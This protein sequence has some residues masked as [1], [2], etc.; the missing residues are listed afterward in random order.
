MMFLSTFLRVLPFLRTLLLALLCLASPGARAVVGGIVD[1]NS[2]NSPFAGVG[3][4][5]RDGREVYSAVLIAPQ[6]A[7]TAAHVV[8]RTAL[9]GTY[10]FNL[11]IGGDLTFSVPVAEIVVHPDYHGF[12][13][14]PDGLVHSDLAV[15]RLASAVPAG[16][17]IYE[18]Y[19]GLVAGQEIVFVGYG[20][21]LDASGASVAPAASVKRRGS[22]EVER[23]LPAQGSG[24][25]AG[26]GD[27]FVFRSWPGQ[28]A[29]GWRAGLAGGDSGG[30]AFVQAPDGRLE[31]AGI[32]TFV[33]GAGPAEAGSFIAGGGGIVVA[34]H[35]PWIKSVMSELPEPAT[36]Q[37]AAIGIALAIA[38]GAAALR[39]AQ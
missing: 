35:V 27:V 37:L 32:N 1:Q 17:P 6:Y 38:A 22:S 9:P 10:T 28:S 26:Q 14:G 2:A 5:I 33:F 36:W 3:S 20:R 7:L 12:K 29:T 19:G 25:D 24:L 8:S 11:N 16:T 21:G 31:L 23:L 39:R 18:L 30:P 15:V 13:R 34:P 4:I